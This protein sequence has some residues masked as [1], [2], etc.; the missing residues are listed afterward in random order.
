VTAEA[1]A[2]PVERHFLVR[3]FHQLRDG[4]DDGLF[5]VEVTVQPADPSRKWPYPLRPDLGK[6]IA[7]LIRADCEE[8]AGER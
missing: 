7:D 8:D 3:E 5:W 2:E 4:D 1:A 6:R